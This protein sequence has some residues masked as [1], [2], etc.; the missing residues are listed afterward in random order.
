MPLHQRNPAAS[1]AARAG[2][3][4]KSG[5]EIPPLSSE[6]IHVDPVLGTQYKTAGLA[7]ILA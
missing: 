5:E 2:A 6:S 4:N 7:V 1:W 3:A